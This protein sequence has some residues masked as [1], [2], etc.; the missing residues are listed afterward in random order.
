MAKGVKET[1][2]QIEAVLFASG[3]PFGATR[4][5]ELLEIDLE[6]LENMVKTINDGYEEGPFQILKLGDAYQM[7][8]KAPYG[9][10]IKKALEVKRNAPLSQAAMEVLAI[11]AYNQPVTR[12]FTEQ[13]RGVDSSSIV[14]SLT[15]KGLICEAGRLEIPGRP[16]AYGTTPAF[17]RCFGMKDIKALPK[18]PNREE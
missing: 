13:V 4:L 8:T 15:A 10:V 11:V 5:A 3:E 7:T 12:S 16:I 17:L 18:L 14:V 1:I 2:N 9:E 6:T